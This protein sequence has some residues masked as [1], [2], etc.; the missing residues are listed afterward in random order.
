[1][2]PLNIPIPEKSGGFMAKFRDIT[3]SVS[4]FAS[5]IR[6]F[7]F[8]MLCDGPLLV[9]CAKPKEETC[10]SLIIYSTWFAIHLLMCL[11]YSLFFLTQG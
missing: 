1:M 11:I 8:A 2:L 9:H 4:D 6:W 3:F 7:S 10:I 5:S